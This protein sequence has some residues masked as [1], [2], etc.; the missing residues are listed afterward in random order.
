MIDYKTRKKL[1]LV[2]LCVII[3]ASAFFVYHKVKK[4]AVSQKSADTE[5]VPA[6]EEQNSDEII[7]KTTKTFTHPDFGFSFDYPDN[8]VLKRFA[9]DGDDS[10][11][12]Q[13][14]DGKN[15]LQVII[16]AYDEKE[17]LSL[18]SVKNAAGELVIGDEKEI[19]IG[20]G[21]K[22][23]AFSFTLKN[24]DADPGDVS[25]VL[26]EIWFT[27]GGKLYQI[28]SYPDFAGYMEKILQ[29]FRFN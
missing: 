10:I 3:L 20:S 2:L 16:S 12:V 29:S 28:S 27:Q 18:A 22:I 14:K 15:G 26:N 1:G 7:S 8:F 13:G 11:A 5:A 19:S 4:P 23:K 25:G 17:D 6:V 21:D 24:P 9:G